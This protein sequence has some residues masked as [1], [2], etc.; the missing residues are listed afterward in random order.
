M[1]Q[2][3]QTLFW[4]LCIILIII[5]SFQVYDLE[6]DFRNYQQ[7]KLAVLSGL[8][9]IA[10]FLA[11]FSFHRRKRQKL[12]SDL[13]LLFL[14]IQVLLFVLDHLN[15]KLLQYIES[16]L[17]LGVAI[18]SN[19]CGSVAIHRDIKLLENSSRLR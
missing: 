15:L 10:L 7:P 13:S 5:S 1:I 18:I 6:M 2:R 16:F 19:I 12:F 8:S 17:L 4:L 11:T 14:L 9:I 3:V